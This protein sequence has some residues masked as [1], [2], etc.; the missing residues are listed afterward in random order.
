[1]KILLT[2]NSVYLPTHGG[3]NKENRVMLEALVE[4][5]HECSV[6]APASGFQASSSTDEFREAL[7]TRGVAWEARPDTDVFSCQGV[8]V[9]A[10]TDRRRMLAALTREIVQRSPDL[11][12]VASEDPGQV[13]LQTALRT[14]PSRVVYVART[15]LAL[16]FGPGAAGDS[17]RRI[18]LV[19][20]A[21]GV[22]VVSR[23][24]QQYFQQWA[25]IE[26]TVLP[27]SLHGPG[28]FPEYGR[29]DR[30][31]ITMINPCAYKGLPIF[32]ELARAFPELSFAAVPTWGTT[33]EDKRRIAQVPN[34]SLL[35][36]VDEIDRLLAVTRVLVVPSLWAENKSRSITEAML[37]GIPVLAGDV[38]GNREAMG[39][40]DYLLPVNPITAFENCVDERMLPVARVPPQDVAPWVTALGDLLATEA[41]YTCVARAART[42]ALARNEDETIIPV[43][44]YLAGLQRRVATAAA[45]SA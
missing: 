22:M 41:S 12:L 17:A 44:A 26:A 13:L 19:K 38:G 40:V 14:A 42:M 28:P 1:M 3:A 43:E 45:P 30:G 39:G 24:L 23:F 10:I 25:G 4:R 32:L 29:Y 11:V 31:V 8:W 33:E 35:E 27:I 5:G 2:Q 6:V 18:D 37:R 21:M 15:T 20:Q 7:R 36:P 34:I 9:A 16:P